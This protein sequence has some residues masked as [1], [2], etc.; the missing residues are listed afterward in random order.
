MLTAANHWC[1]RSRA[2]R[3]RLPSRLLRP[4]PLGSGVSNRRPT[5]ACGPLRNQPA[6]SAYPQETYVI[7]LR[8]DGR[9]CLLTTQPATA[10]AFG[11]ADAYQTYVQWFRGEVTAGRRKA[12]Y[13]GKP[14][15]SGSLLHRLSRSPKR[16]GWPAGT[17]H[18]F[19]ISHNTPVR[20]LA[21]ALNLIK[22]DWHWVARPNGARWTKEDLQRLYPPTP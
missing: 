12:K 4:R 5:G 15:P 19:R 11:W 18:S 9:P 17:V 6:M 14:L 21:D 2:L 16:R 3:L 22:V 20:E 7:S 13:D 10:A 8:E 1:S